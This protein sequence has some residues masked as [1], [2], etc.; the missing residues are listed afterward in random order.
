MEELKQYKL[1]IEAM[2][3][4]VFYV[5]DASGFLRRW[6]PPKIIEQKGDK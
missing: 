2:Q 3:G 6:Y 5:E 1:A 4:H